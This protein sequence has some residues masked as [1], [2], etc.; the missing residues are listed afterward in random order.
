MNLPRE[1]CRAFPCPRL[2]CGGPKNPE[3]CTA[4]EHGAGQRQA[5]FARFKPNRAEP[6]CF[7]WAFWCSL[8]KNQAAE[9]ACLRP[10]R[11]ATVQAS[12]TSRP[13]PAQPTAAVVSLGREAQQSWHSGARRAPPQSVTDR[14]RRAPAF[15]NGQV[16]GTRNS[17]PETHHW[18]RPSHDREPHFIARKTASPTANPPSA[19]G[20]HS[21]RHSWVSGPDAAAPRRL[22]PCG[23]SPGT[24]TTASILT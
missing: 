1:G 3:P 13:P 2:A 14:L 22:T 10:P 20:T 15:L 19:L 12:R 4:P 7:R 23:T 17:P 6:T 9:E 24:R 5:D 16:C 21:D 11:R 8:Y 18:S